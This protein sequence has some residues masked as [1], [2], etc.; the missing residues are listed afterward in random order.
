MILCSTMAD[1][2]HPSTPKSFLTHQRLLEALSNPSAMVINPRGEVFPGT[3]YPTAT[4]TTTV[5]VIISDSSGLHTT[6]EEIIL[7]KRH[8]L[9]PSHP[10]ADATPSLNFPSENTSLLSTSTTIPPSDS[11]TPTIDTTTLTLALAKAPHTLSTS[12]RPHNISL[13]LPTKLTYANPHWPQVGTIVAESDIPQ[14]WR[15]TVLDREVRAQYGV[16]L[17]VC[18]VFILGVLDV[19]G[20]SWIRYVSLPFTK[21]EQAMWTL[22][23]TSDRCW[24]RGDCICSRRREKGGKGGIEWYG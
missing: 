5:E 18:G 20:G 22:I 3:Y 4:A 10:P 11:P 6:L 15:E 8:A 14:R 12:T 24:S 19:L 17:A 1:H 23:L 9:S 7:T 2:G 21:M 13:S 16:L